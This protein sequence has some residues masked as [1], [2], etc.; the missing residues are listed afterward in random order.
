MFK[1]TKI[2]REYLNKNNSLNIFNPPLMKKYQLISHTADLGI[3]VYGRSREEIF[4]NSAYAM[5]DLITDLEK[6]QIKDKIELKAF[7]DDENELLIDWLRHLHS[8]YAVDEYLF[9]KF[10]ILDLTAHE[11]RGIAEGE[12]FNPEIHS[13][14]KEIKA[15]T[16]HSMGIV[17][18][19]SLYKTQIIFDV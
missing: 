16:Y 11:V 12:K 8:Y 17:K 2:R 5:F 18:E 7:S 14:K 15:V 13:I 4:L 1:D 19:K 6:V 10:Q 3:E 9:R